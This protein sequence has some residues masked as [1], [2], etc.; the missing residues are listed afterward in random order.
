MYWIYLTL[1]VLVI[2]TP[3]FV[4]GDATYLREEDI[5]SLFIFC[6]GTFGFLAYLAKEKT[7]LRAIREKLHLQKQ[8]N[9]ITRDLSDSYSYI[10][11]MNRK[12]DI[13]KE[14]I[15]NLP[16]MVVS[17]SGKKENHRYSSLLGTV[18]LLGKTEQVA[19]CFIN[20]KKK[21]IE[22][23]IEKNNRKLFGKYL[24]AESLL[25]EGK[26]FWEEQ[27]YAVVRSPRQAG[28][29]AAFLIFSK[30]KNHIEDS[31]VFKILVSQALLLYALDRQQI[32]QD[33]GA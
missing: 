22:K 5:E 25:A 31:D 3:Q 27:D 21:T 24:N 9:M 4:F 23:V 12:L 20:V 8:T 17:I 1:F 10:G 11:E 7:L 30:T 13:V 19:L 29:V 33:S 32:G 14:F 28:G 15:F 26:F 18:A 2:L 6:F 16:R